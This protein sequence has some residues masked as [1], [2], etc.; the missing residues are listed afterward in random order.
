MMMMLL[1]PTTTRGGGGGG[2]ALNQLSSPPPLHHR[3]PSIEPLPYALIP[4]KLGADSCEPIKVIPEARDD[5]E[6]TL[7]CRKTDEG[8][9]VK[10]FRLSPIEAQVGRMSTVEGNINPHPRLRPENDWTK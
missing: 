8:P 1:M 4:V 10:Q 9:L 2:G 3:M 5:W 7:C 6:G